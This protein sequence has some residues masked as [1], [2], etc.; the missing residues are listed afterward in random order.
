LNVAI[1]ALEAL[2]IAVM[3]LVHRY[4]LKGLASFFEDRLRAQDEAEEGRRVALY[5]QQK[6]TARAVAQSDRAVR[7]LADET[8]HLK[9]EAE[10]ALH[11]IDRHI[12][13]QKRE[14]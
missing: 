5:K 13:D 14:G 9:D 8:R 3:L 10:L 12:S 7:K 1:F 6:A 2:G 4:N 11:R